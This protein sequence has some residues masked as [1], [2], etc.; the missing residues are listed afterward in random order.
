MV[1]YWH[2]WRVDSSRTDS[3]YHPLSIMVYINVIGIYCMHIN[4]CMHTYY[5][6]GIFTLTGNVSQ[7]NYICTY[8]HICI[9]CDILKIDSVNHLNRSNHYFNLK[10]IILTVCKL[11]IQCIYKSFDVIF[12]VDVALSLTFTQILHGLTYY[13]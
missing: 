3:T 9:M 2:F 4:I 6:R 12:H 1:K 13:V 10:P 8:M 5:N 11:K 7:R